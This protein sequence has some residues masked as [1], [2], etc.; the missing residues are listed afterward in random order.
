MHPKDPGVESVAIKRWDVNTSR[1]DLLVVFKSDEHDTDT[2]AHEEKVP[3][4]D[5][6]HAG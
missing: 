4:A 2:H 6:D 3:Y 1:K 5:P